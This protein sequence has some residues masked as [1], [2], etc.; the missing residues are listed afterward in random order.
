M[1]RFL[2]RGE[3]SSSRC[4]LRV[5]DRDARQEKSLEALSLIEAT[6]GW[7]GIACQLCHALIRGFP[8]IG[9]AQE[10]HM[11]GLVDPEEVFERVAFFLPTVRLLLLLR[12]F[13]TLAWSFGPL[14]KKREEGAE[15]SVG[16]LASIAA[17]SSA[18]RAGS[19]S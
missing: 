6:A 9:V 15:A 4:F 3:R 2:R 13:R 14:M 12:V 1:G 17:K 5:E 16:G 18:V 7:Q 10:A 19:R 8:F 11:T